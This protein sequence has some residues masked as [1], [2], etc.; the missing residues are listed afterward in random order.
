[1][2]HISSVHDTPVRLGVVK[3]VYIYTDFNLTESDSSHLAL[4]T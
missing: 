1:M 2:F 4:D 3:W